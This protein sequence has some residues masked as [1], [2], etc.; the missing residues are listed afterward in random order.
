MTEPKRQKTLKLKKTIFSSN[1]S[2]S[3]LKP[4]KHFYWLYVPRRSWRVNNSGLYMIAIGL[5]ET[6]CLQGKDGRSGT[7]FWTPLKLSDLIILIIVLIIVWF[8]VPEISV[9]PAKLSE[10]S[11][12]TLEKKTHTAEIVHGTTEKNRGT[13]EAVTGT[14]EKKTISSEGDLAD[15]VLTFDANLD[16]TRL[17]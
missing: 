16:L 5:S 12:V 9:T 15:K 4:R 7:S 2:L 13:E 10:I 6:K 11:S 17:S 8:S 1:L 14:T 3:S